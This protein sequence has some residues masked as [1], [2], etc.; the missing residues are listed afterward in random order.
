[1]AIPTGAQASALTQPNQRIQFVDAN[2]FLTS[3]AQL[4]LQ[5]IVNYINGGN[6]VIPMS[7]AGANLLTLT[8]NTAS[9]NLQKYVDF[10]QFPFIAAQNSTGAVTA[11]VV[12]TTGALATLPVY[13]P[14]GTTPVAAGDI[15]AGTF[16][17]LY[18]SSTANGFILK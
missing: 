2:G 4:L 15:V 5:Q 3:P 13:K 12:P 11:T 10:E 17:I 6:R 7:V 14:D 18:Y 9:P 16:Y 8:P 1:M